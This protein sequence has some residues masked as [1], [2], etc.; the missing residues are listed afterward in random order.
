MPRITRYW[1]MAGL[2]GLLV[3]CGG[4]GGGDRAQGV[5]PGP[6]PP[7]QP[8]PPPDPIPPAP[9]TPYA[10]AEQLVAHITSV[11]IPDDGNPVVE[12]QLTD[13]SGVA[14]LDLE[15]NNVRFTLA[16]LQTSELGNL[17]GSWQSYINRIETAG[18]VGPG[19]E[20]KL[21][22]TYEREEGEFTN[23]GDG[24]YR[25]K[26]A[27]NVNEPP[28]D[29]AAQAETQGLDLSYDPNLTHRVA[30]QFDG[31]DNTT[32]NPNYDWVP[33]TGATSGIFN[34]DIAATENC[35]RCHDPLQIHGSNRREIEYCVTCHNPG[36]TDANSGNTVNLKV[37]V[38]KIHMGRD[39][40]SVQE[41][42]EYAIWGFR[43]SKHDYSHLGYPQDIRN[44]VNC[45]VGSATIGDRDDLVQTSQGDNWAEVPSEAVC[46]SCHENATGHTS[47][48]E[49]TECASCHSAGGRAGSIAAS[50]A[51]PVW[52]AADNQ[53]AAKIERVE[54]AMPGESAEVTFRITNP[55]SGEDWD[56]KNDPAFNSDGSR[57]AVG[58]A[59]STTDYTNTGNEGD[60]ASSVQTTDVASFTDNGDG[61]FTATMPVAIPDGSL[62]PNVAAGGSGT[63]TIEGHPVLDV[64]DEEDGP[65]EIPLTNAHLHFSIDEADGGAVDRREQVE[66][67]NCLACHGKLS[68]H[69]GNRND[70]IESCVTCHN[71]RNTDRRVRDIASNP[72]TDGKQE[73][74]LDFKVMVHGIHAAGIRENP[75]QIVGFRGFT[76]YVFD[77]EHVHYPGDL[78]NCTTCHND[79]GYLLPLQDG[80][81]ATTIDT[82]DDR[83][84]PADDTVVTPVSSVCSSCHDGQEAKAHMTG[85]GGNFATTQA[86]ID[87][88]DVVEQCSVCHG[89][90][91]NADVAEVHNPR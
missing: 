16:K 18:S 41:G 11:T 75:L 49:D 61:T 54:N 27:A 55:E 37:M 81:L 6:T 7:G 88:G 22:A 74:T 23:N 13:G 64:S 20:D 4:G 85:N 76:T 65:E 58:V 67:E 71:P 32:V 52:E 9:L 45:H 36:T 62:P 46:T 5:E 72:P 14:I 38:H 17:T 33:A 50:H 19:T 83:A 39:L 44:C 60:N 8:V 35:N 3:A 43:D 66:I 63:A 59:W 78:S 82:G 51:I 73:E 15:P 91:R 31:N 2:M 12:W 70:S 1:I 21:Q 80:V 57:L 68:L 53:F 89:E 77:E 26:M 56:I 29:V 24:T 42:G 10:E 34:M 30:M 79:E 25:Y 87:D 48:Y 69:G 90:G 40:P 86:A 84:D 28:E 47:R